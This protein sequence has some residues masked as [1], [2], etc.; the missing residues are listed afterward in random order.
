[1]CDVNRINEITKELMALS[2]KELRQLMLEA[3][4]DE[5]RDYYL[6]IYNYSLAKSQREVLRGQH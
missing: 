2:F 4:S 1:M 3:D 6:N 5:L